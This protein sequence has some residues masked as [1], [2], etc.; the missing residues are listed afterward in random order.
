MNYISVDYFKK[1]VTFKRLGFLK[2]VFYRK[3]INAPLGLI[4][5][6][7]THLLLCKGCMGVFGLR[8]RYKD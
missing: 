2:V 6:L 4:S 3:R 7:F 1:E 5:T 8:V